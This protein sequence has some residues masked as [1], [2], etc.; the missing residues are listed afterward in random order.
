MGK[1]NQA[2]T[3]AV[4][5]AVKM[6]TGD[7]FP[8][9]PT[10]TEPITDRLVAIGSSTVSTIETKKGR[11]AEIRKTLT[12]I[13]GL[14][15]AGD[16]A[17]AGEFGP[18]NAELA[19]IDTML[20]SMETRVATEAQLVRALT[21]FIN[22]TERL[23][24]AGGMLSVTDTFTD[25]NFVITVKKVPVNKAGAVNGG[26]DQKTAAAAVMGIDKAATSTKPPKVSVDG[27]DYPSFAA[28]CDALGINHVGNSAKRVLDS[29][30]HVTLYLNL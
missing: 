7:N 3:E 13:G 11:A 12:E 24:W 6:E 18:L 1:Q 14:I 8:A 15:A 25:N 28:A 17:R 26:T 23:S 29:K 21:S 30:G 9:A 5:E 16:F 4:V 22:E 2:V 10:Q 20:A 19:A 27:I